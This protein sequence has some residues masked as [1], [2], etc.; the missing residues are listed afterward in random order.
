MK[1]CLSYY[2][3][4]LRT[5]TKSTQK[6]EQVIETTKTDCGK[7]EEAQP[8]GDEEEQHTGFIGDVL[9]VDAPEGSLDVGFI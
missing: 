5:G 2:C 1:P 4:C 9:N 6:Q 3:I 8:S 7:V